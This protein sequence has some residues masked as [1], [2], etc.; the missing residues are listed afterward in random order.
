[1]QIKRDLQFCKKENLYLNYT[2]IKHVCPEKHGRLHR[3]MRCGLLFECEALECKAQFNVLP[4]LIRE[5]K[6]VEHCP[7]NPSWEWIRDLIS[8]K[9]D[10]LDFTDRPNVEAYGRCKL[11]DIG[12]AWRCHKPEGHKGSCSCHNDC[13]EASKDHVYCS[14]PPNHCG[15]H[16][17]EENN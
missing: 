16:G 14:Y 10:Q 4:S 5:G 17:W 9:I 8:A 13:G 11:R 3:C 7:S 6:V 1:M 12:F 2:L 15:K